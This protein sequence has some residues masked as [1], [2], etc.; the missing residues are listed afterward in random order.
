MKKFAV[1]DIDGTLVRWQLYHA[2]TDKL[3]NQGLLG[4]NAKEQLHTARM[5]WKVRQNPDSFRKYEQ[6]LIE[7]FE[8]AVA[9]LSAQALEQA[10]NE[11]SQTYNDQV[12]TYGRNL[13]KE[14]KQQGYFLLAISGSHQEL[15]Q[16]IA[17]QYGF[18]DWRGTVYE[19]HGDTFT[20]KSFVASHNKKAILTEL[21]AK[22]KLSM[23]GSI[24][25]G[26]SASDAPMLEIVE[27][28]IAF[29]PDRL[30]FELARQHN[31]KIVVERK[32][33]IY[34]LEPKDGRY[35]LL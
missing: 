33:V 13:I 2:L 32:N 29:N 16:N 35:I 7:V 5:H 24:A 17:R 14:L 22:H 27:H 18:D 8:A 9:G 20:G 12:Y 19:R 26:D 31:W 6:V 11:V 30:L 10:A 1:F 23:Q 3:A 34:E 15:V 25:V 4:K 21:V 28:P